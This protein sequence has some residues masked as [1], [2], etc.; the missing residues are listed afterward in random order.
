[1][2]TNPSL[3]RKFKV[4]GGPGGYWMPDTNLRGEGKGLFLVLV[5]RVVEERVERAGQLHLHHANITNQLRRTK[6]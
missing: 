6:P 2:G 5:V 3:V 1:M 4:G